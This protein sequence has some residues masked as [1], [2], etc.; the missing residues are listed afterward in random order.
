ML[1]LSSVARRCAGFGLLLGACMAAQGAPP[2]TPSNVIYTSAPKQMIFEWDIVPQSNYY[3]LW[4]KAND[5]APFVKFGERRPWDPQWHNNV[6]AHLLN[7]SQARWE[8]RACNPS[9]C[10]S[11]GPIDTGSTVVNTVGY[12]KTGHPVAEAR[13]GN[14]VAVSEDGKTFAA[15]ASDEPV[16]NGMAAAVYVFR[17]KSGKWSQIGRFVPALC[18]TAGDAEDASLSLRTDGGLIVVALPHERAGATGVANAGAVHV[19]SHSSSGGWSAN[20]IFS[21]PSG[22]HVG[23]FAQAN[24]GGDIVAYSEDAGGGRIEVWGASAGHWTRLTEITGGGPASCR[25]DLSG[26]GQWLARIC[27]GSAHIEILNSHTGVRHAN[28]G[29]ALPAGHE[30]GAVALDADAATLAFESRPHDV[31]QG[32]YVAAN[33]KPAVQVLR[34][35]SAGAYTRV[36]TLTP[37]STQSTEYAKRSFFGDSLTISHDATYVAVNDPHDSLGRHGV[38]PPDEIGGGGSSAPPWGA[39][40][41]FERAGCGYRLRRHVGPGSV[42]DAAAEG[43]FGPPALGNDGKTMV[44]GNPL[45]DGSRSGIGP[46]LFSA[47]L[48]GSGA[49]W[50]Y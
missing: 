33:W 26:N 30:I 21:N 42:P 38:W 41:L 13:F 23:T 20:H 31:S 34:R 19:F 40:Y 43:V 44:I 1:C 10:S 7:W 45:D 14:A 37:W 22:G 5:G 16:A 15:I 9:G 27:N 2:A 48:E 24:D 36:A 46:Y 50:L 39:I 47:Q 11:T 35:T 12:V 32:A 28:V 3:E 17:S 29:P 4:F 8:I 18:P 6:S 25:L 49:V